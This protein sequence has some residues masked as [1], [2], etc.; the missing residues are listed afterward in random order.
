MTPKKTTTG[1]IRAL[2][3]DLH[4]LLEQGVDHA[5]LLSHAH[6]QHGH[7]HHAQGGVGGEVAHGV[8]KHIGQAVLGQQADGGDGGLRQFPVGNQVSGSRNAQGG[9]HGGDYN[10][11]QA[12]DGEQGHGMGQLVA[13][14]LDAVEPTVIRADLL[15]V[16]VFCH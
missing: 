8:G 11:Q 14:P 7:Q 13:H 10:H 9:A 16:F 3:G 2:G 5:G 15:E 6:A 4:G 12:E 1:V